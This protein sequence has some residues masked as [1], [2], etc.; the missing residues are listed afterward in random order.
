MDKGMQISRR[1]R[2]KPDGAGSATEVGELRQDFVTG[3]WVLVAT[4]RAKRPSD[5][6]EKRE[7]PR[8]PPKFKNDCPF[9]RLDKYPQEPDV[10]RLPDDAENWQVHVFGNKYPALRP[11][12]DFT[13]WQTGP[14]RVI[15]PIGFHEVLATRWH[16][17][18]D[19]I[20]TKA[21]MSLQLEALVLRY[22]QLKIKASVN[23]IQI[24]KNHGE[25]AGGSLEHP[26][27]Q[28]FTL[29]ILPSDVQDMM[30]G[31]E[32]YAKERGHEPYGVMVEFEQ[33]KK[34]RVVYENDNFVAYC[35]FVSRTP[36]EVWVMPK[37]HGSYF[38]NIGPAEREALA[39]A[40][41]N[42]FARLYVGLNDPHYNYYIYSA[43]C[44]DTGFVSGSTDFSNFRWHVEIFPRLGLWGGFELG[45]GLEIMSTLPEK[46]AAFLREQ[47]LIN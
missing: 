28:I 39:D 13:A 1:I 46:A 10:L 8:R 11:D 14:Y 19:A 33:E 26:H 27:H 9:C 6:S 23:Y 45:T 16:D 36:F 21:Q 29:P 3:K 31:A 22:R 17:Q 5:F 4:G 41:Q 2:V 7:K 24:I 38:E 15:E 20:L 44:D 32:R 35:P 25:D 30:Y 12:D 43:P 34:E 47:K 18:V 40:M 37:K 42:V